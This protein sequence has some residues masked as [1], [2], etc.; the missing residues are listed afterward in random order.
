MTIPQRIHADLKD[1]MRARDDVRRRTLR[2]LRAALQT[3]EID[4]REQQDDELSE[5]QVLVVLRKQAKQRRDAMAQYEEAGRD[6]LA[7]R[8]R[9]ELAIVEEYLPQPLTDA[10]LRAELQ[11]VVDEVG[12]TSMQDMG[13]VMGAAMGRLRGRADGRRVQQQVRALLNEDA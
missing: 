10:E 6:D 13:R 2:S 7:A 9:E 12:A 8:E 3:A 11:A 1:A 4:Q 5:E